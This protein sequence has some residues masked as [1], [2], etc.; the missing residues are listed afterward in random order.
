MKP[1]D[2]KPGH[3]IVTRTIGDLT[4]LEPPYCDITGDL[5][6]DRVYVDAAPGDQST[7]WDADTLPAETG[8]VGFE[9]LGLNPQRY[10]LVFLPNTEVTV[11]RAP[12]GR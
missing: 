6:W 8:A 3:R 12:D 11:R 4:V 1:A 7:R 10:R 2:L 5:R 9:F